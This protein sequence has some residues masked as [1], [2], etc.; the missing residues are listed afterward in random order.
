MDYDY[1]ILADLDEA[2]LSYEFHCLRVIKKNGSNQ[3]AYA[4]DSGCSCPSPFETY[5]N[6]DSYNRIA[7]STLGEFAKAVYDFPAGMEEKHN[8]VK[9]VADKLQED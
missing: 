6:F 4:V 3:Y 8:L 1:S 2:G 7:L 5:G 9:K